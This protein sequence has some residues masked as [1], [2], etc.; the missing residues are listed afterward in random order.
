[1]ASARRRL[2]VAVTSTR[3]N[4]RTP[5]SLGRALSRT[6]GDLAVST[7]PVASPVAPA[8]RSIAYK[9]L[10]TLPVVKDRN[11]SAASTVNSK[12]RPTPSADR[13][14]TILLPF[15]AVIL[16]LAL[17]RHAVASVTK[18]FLLPFAPA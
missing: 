1:M 14:P 3:T 10:L 13:A 12:G 17:T 15:A 2:P 18:T 5:C 16:S 4:V 7:L 8:D 9:F 6:L 11:M